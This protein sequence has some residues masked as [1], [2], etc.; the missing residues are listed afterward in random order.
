M[1]H[2]IS[3]LYHLYIILYHLYIA[4]YVRYLRWIKMQNITKALRFSPTSP[5]G[6][7][8]GDDISF[9][10]LYFLSGTYS[11]ISILPQTRLNKYMRNFFSCSLVVFWCWSCLYFSTA[12]GSLGRSWESHT[13]PST[14]SPHKYNMSASRGPNSLKASQMG[15]V[16]F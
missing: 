4:V 14:I 1:Y 8:P 5:K 6:S 12:S 9:I 3:F 15:R 11:L 10:I 16:I 13:I 7:L 2:F